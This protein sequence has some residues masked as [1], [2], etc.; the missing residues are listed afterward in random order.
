MTKFPAQKWVRR[1]NGVIARQ[2]RNYFSNL[3][4][5]ITPKNFRNLFYLWTFSK[6]SE[7][8]LSLNNLPAPWSIKFDNNKIRRINNFIEIFGRESNNSFGRLFPVRVAQLDK[9]R[10]NFSFL[11]SSSPVLNQSSKC[12][13]KFVVGRVIFQKISAKNRNFTIQKSDKISKI[14]RK[15]GRKSTFWQKIENRN[16]N[17]VSQKSKMVLNFELSP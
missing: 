17:F 16:C 14:S 10:N 5:K 15:R 9:F 12:W 8:I 11:S 6:F 7:F 3:L 13:P 1:K 4:A 2:V